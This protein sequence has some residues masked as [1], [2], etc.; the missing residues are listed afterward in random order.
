MLEL[1]FCLEKKGEGQDLASW[2][3]GGGLWVGLKR[4]GIFVIFEFER[5]EFGKLYLRKRNRLCR[6]GEKHK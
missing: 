4:R 6:M 1:C 3:F 5:D 2:K